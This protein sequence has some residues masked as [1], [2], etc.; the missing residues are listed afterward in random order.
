MSALSTCRRFVLLVGVCSLSSAAILPAI[1]FGTVSAQQAG[2]KASTTPHALLQVDREAANPSQEQPARMS[3]EEFADLLDLQ[4]AL[5]KSEL[6]LKSALDKPEVAKLPAVKQQQ[7]PLT[8]LAMRL[9]IEALK[10]TGILRVAVTGGPPEEQAVLVNAVADAYLQEVAQKDLHRRRARLDKLREYMT[11]Y[12]AMLQGKRESL[13]QVSQ[14]VGGKDGIV[15]QVQQRF[16][17]KQVEAVEKELLEIQGQIRKARIEALLARVAAQDEK[18]AAEPAVQ[19]LTEAIEKDR[20][21]ALLLA[22][23]RE[24][25]L[26]IAMFKEK[27]AN[28][29]AEPAYQNAIAEIEHDRKALAKRRDEIAK[30]VQEHQRRDAKLTQHGAQQRIEHLRKIEELL[31]DE[32]ENRLKAIQPVT[33]PSIDLD[34]LREDTHQIETLLQEIT[35]QTHSLQRELQAPPRVRILQP[36]TVP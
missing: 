31:T 25:E 9:K 24:L 19:A 26:R 29:S 33:K 17:V 21:A 18:P 32:R 13:R 36:A 30:Q 28:P 7:D 8:W 23:I 3:S 4:V 20:V 14:Q 6:I 12:E 11:G 15:L 35:R 27:T 34:R 1:L 2:E 22:R 16:A 10:R 5:L